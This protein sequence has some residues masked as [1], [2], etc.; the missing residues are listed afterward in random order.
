M[1]NESGETRY[2][3]TTD[4]VY[5]NEEAEEREFSR[6]GEALKRGGKE[7]AK[8]F[9]N[10]HEGQKVIEAAKVG[11]EKMGESLAGVM[12]STKGYYQAITDTGKKFMVKVPGL[13]KKATEAAKNK[14]DKAAM[15]VAKA[16]VQGYGDAGREMSGA[17]DEVAETIRSATKRR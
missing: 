12:E 16:G 8:A 17:F 15:K 11:A 5:S 1:E 2:F 6:F 13:T 14:I 9:K 4:Y 10:T 7:A 3:S